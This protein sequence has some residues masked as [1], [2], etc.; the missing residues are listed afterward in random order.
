MT[1]IGFRRRSRKLGVVASPCGNCVSGQLA[2]HKV[3][4]WFTLFAIPLFPVHFRYVTVCPNCK[5]RRDVPRD[6]LDHVRSLLPRI[7]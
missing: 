1:I 2:L 5:A 6:E 7:D 4:R 3:A